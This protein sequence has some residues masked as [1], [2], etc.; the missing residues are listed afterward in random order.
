MVPYADHL[1]AFR[2]HFEE[3][4][5]L[6]QKNVLVDLVCGLII[7]LLFFI[8]LIYVQSC[9]AIVYILPF[10]PFIIYLD[11]AKLFPRLVAIVNLFFNL[12]SFSMFRFIV[13]VGGSEGNG[14][15]ARGHL[16]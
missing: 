8:Y 4:E 1:T 16:R 7:Y 9:Y 13:A 3:Q 14:K 15:G 12:D 6:Y 10:I 11:V 2:S 5:R